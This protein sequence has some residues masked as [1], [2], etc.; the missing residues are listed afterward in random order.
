MS[1]TNAE[2]KQADAQVQELQDTKTLFESLALTLD[3]V[4]AKTREFVDV[5]DIAM[6]SAADSPD[7]SALRL[8]SARFANVTA[9]MVCR[10]AVSL[11]CVSLAPLTHMTPHE[12]LK[13]IFTHSSLLFHSFI[14]IL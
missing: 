14:A 5:V 12:R 11:V 4:R 2:Q 10:L 3:D 1:D 6:N 9:P 7:S 8:H 13:E